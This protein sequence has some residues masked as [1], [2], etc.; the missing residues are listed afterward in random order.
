M[1]RKL[2]ALALFSVPLLLGARVLKSS[3]A[4][5]VPDPKLRLTA[6][7]VRDTSRKGILRTIKELSGCLL[8]LKEA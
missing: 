6:G 1:F 5:L 4:A 7:D 8:G 3:W 2:N